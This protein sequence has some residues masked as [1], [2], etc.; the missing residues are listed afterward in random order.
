MTRTAKGRALGSIVYGIADQ[1]LLA[2]QGGGALIAMVLLGLW[3][4]R[5]HL[6]DVVRK[7][8]GRGADVDD[9]DEIMSYR[10]AVVTLV[11]GLVGM[12]GWL[13]LMGTK[14]WVPLIL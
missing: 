9:G 4:G 5:E 6:R 8:F 12:V 14:L 7:A 13:W 2:Y 3:S 11:A 10:A 1:P